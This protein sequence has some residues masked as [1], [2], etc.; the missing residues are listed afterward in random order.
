MCGRGTREG[1][2]CREGRGT[3]NGYTD[4]MRVEVTRAKKSFLLPSLSLDLGNY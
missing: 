2:H 1:M 3:E 4:M